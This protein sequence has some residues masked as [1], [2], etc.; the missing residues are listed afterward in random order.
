MLPLCGR[1][2]PSPDT[3]GGYCRDHRSQGTLGVFLGKLEIFSAAVDGAFT[4]LAALAVANTVASLFY[5]LRWLAPLFRLTPAEPSAT[6]L[7]VSGRWSAATA[8]T[9]GAASLLLGIAGGAVLPLTT[10]PLLP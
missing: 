1:H 7:T 6:A 10:G 2:Q 5:Y 4:W 9:A 8:Y 3:A